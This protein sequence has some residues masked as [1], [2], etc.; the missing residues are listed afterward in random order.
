MTPPS[1]ANPPTEHRPPP[2]ILLCAGYGTR[3]GPL[4]ATTPKPLLEVAGR[5]VLDHLLERLLPLPRLGILHVVS[6]SHYASAFDAWARAWNA[7]L[8]EAR[9]CVHDDGSRS[10]DDRLGA[11]GDLAFV[12]SRLGDDP[13]ADGALVMAGDNIF[14]FSLAPLWQGLTQRRE[15]TVLALHESDQQRLRRT[16][17]LELDDDHRVLRLHEKPEHPPSSWA[18]PSIYALRPTALAC[19]DA[20]L[21]SGQGSDEIGRFIGHLVRQQTVR[22]VPT[23]GER[24]HV[25]SPQELAHADQVLRHET[26]PETT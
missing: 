21:A 10:A 3:M 12:A 2:A 14:R 19:L 4:T 16:G 25:G 15:T 8:G 5:P 18:C 22:A 24:L 9:I 13:L 11:I 20:Y 7:R 6:N 26:S 23:H 1:A 17:V